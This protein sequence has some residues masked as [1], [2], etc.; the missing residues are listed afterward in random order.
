M[1]LS[2]PLRL[3][4]RSLKEGG[5]RDESRAGDSSPCPSNGR[6]KLSG[7]V[8]RVP[9]VD[10]RA[11]TDAVDG[12]RGKGSVPGHSDGLRLTSQPNHQSWPDTTKVS[13]TAQVHQNCPSGSPLTREYC[14][15][16]CGAGP[17]TSVHPDAVPPVQYER[18]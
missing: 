6:Q 11:R 3:M 13:S 9:R 14:T 15:P 2:G 17:F 18:M 5:G 8:H 12:E 4:A 16:N 7:T 1:P 10:S